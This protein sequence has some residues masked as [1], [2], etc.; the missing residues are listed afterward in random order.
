MICSAEFYFV[1][2]KYNRLCFRNGGTI[3][4]PM[5]R[6]RAGIWIP[7]AVRPMDSVRAAQKACFTELGGILFSICRQAQSSLHASNLPPRSPRLLPLSPSSCTI[8]SADWPQYFTYCTKF[9]SSYLKLSNFDKP[10][11]FAVNLGKLV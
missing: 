9:P 7:N 10:L 2:T 3:F 5:I 8:V 11:M 1:C 4:A 6:L